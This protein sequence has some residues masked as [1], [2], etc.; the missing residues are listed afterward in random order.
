MNVYEYAMEMEK[1][2]E[3][4][5]R[6]LA[7]HCPVEGVRSI[8]TMLANEEVKHYNTIAYLQKRAGDFPPAETLVL[9]NAKNVFTR[10]KEE[11]TDI[12][13]ASSDLESYRKAVAIEEMS[14]EFYLD[15]AADVEEE[16]VRQIFLRLAGEE[17]KH[18][19]IMENIVEFVARPEP[20][21]WLE[22][23]EW[24]HLDEY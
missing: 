21:N 18:F 22:N 16:D 8:L 13:F 23:A 5:Y 20:G 3:K 24:H 7:A 11:K 2:G 17:E 4:Y 12:R 1:D 6:E 10:M 9:E 15:K 19:R 14:R